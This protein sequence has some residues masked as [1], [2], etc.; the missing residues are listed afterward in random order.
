M[1]NISNLK[2]RDFEAD[3]VQGSLRSTDDLV[4]FEHLLV[5]RK[6]NQFA[7]SGEYR[8]PKDLRDAVMQPAKIDMSLNAIE[9]GD[10]W[11]PDSPNRI[12]G[13]LQINGRVEWN[14]GVGNGQVSIYGSNL[15]V[16]GLVF[17]QL[18]AQY[19][20]VNSTVYL[21]DFSASLNEHDYV[22]A[23]AIVNLRPPYRYSGKIYANIAD[24]ATLKPLLRS[25]GNQ[26]DIAGSFFLNW[27]GSGEAQTFKNSGKLK[28]ALE[29]GRYGNLQ[30]LQAN[31]DASYSP[32]GL[33]IPIIFFGSDKMDFQAVA[34]AKGNTLEVSK[35]QVD[36]GQAKYAAGYLS[37]PFI[38][39]NVGT[40][41]RIFPS[42][43][44]VNVTFQSENLDLK[45]L[46]E[47]FGVKAPASG[48][49]NVKVDAQGT[50]AD[51]QARFDLQMRDLRA[52]KFPDFEPASF[53][54]GA[55]VEKGQLAV[56][57]KLQ[58]TKI[59]PVEI[60]AH[61]PFD[62]PKVIEQKQVSDE[63]PVTAKV[64]MPRSSVNF[65]RQFVPAL[66]EIDGD[67]ALDVNVNGTIAN[68]VL[69][70]TGDMTI[71]VMRFTNATLPA[72]RD[73]KTRLDFNRDTLTLQHCG[74]E[75]AGGPFT[76][77]GRI[78]FPKLTEPNIDLQLKA[79]S[80]LVARN[81]T[82]TARTDADVR[83]NG[84]LRT[85]SVT[86]NVALTNSQFLKNI[87][88]IPIG[89]PGRPAPEPPSSRP[90]FS[91]PD[92][93]LR[94]W[95]FDVV[96]KTKDPFLIRGNLANGG[97][98]VDL[99]L[100]GTGLRPGLQGTVRLEEVEATLPFSRLEV[101]YGYLYFDPDD[102]LNPKIDLHGTSLIRDYTV[103]V[104]VYGNSL[105]PEAIFT[106]EPPLPQ[107]EIISLLATGT[108][109]QE[110]TG[111]N[112]VLVGRAAMLLVQQ[113]Y[114]KIFK[115]GEPTKSNSVFDR[116]QVDLG[117]V[118]PKTGQQTATARFK[119]NQNFVVVGDI[120][121][122]GDFRG[123]LKYLIRFR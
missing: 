89:L 98:I 16:R 110:L 80:V 99:K 50:L 47:D 27:E 28:L 18:S 34:Q 95:K 117:N 58:Q 114:R 13:P 122:A 56:A 40:G 82:L 101:A 14:N 24:L 92:P 71:N 57:G 45:K 63:T 48:S 70:G 112:N 84:P 96:I 90:D 43:G 66:E 79:T 55:R 108:T 20:I 91:F 85:A 12:T 74:G 109:R 21:N 6:Q 39:K 17:R 115:K 86:G 65:I 121:V 49:V 26:N 116:L 52:E 87:D 119:I 32:E 100:S 46:F 4:T 37:L 8:L 106:S 53:D 61:L 104:Y 9:L 59:Q 69:S 38:W 33:D 77:S 31:V 111:N 75:L 118:D 72:L 3:A 78:T 1:L 11:K 35:I 42:Q 60:E 51:L 62:I 107:E 15:R 36:Q 120:G 81:D 105:S 41:Q 25:S 88:L 22:S 113:L 76:V 103:H 68:P 83:V 5:T 73:F 23:N 94:D 54:L 19:S 44:K 93:P 64:R 30:S 10:Y 67:L 7:V 102:S 97:A 123:T 29:K 2:L